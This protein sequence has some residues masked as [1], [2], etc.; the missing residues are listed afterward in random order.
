MS[1]TFTPGWDAAKLQ[2]VPVLGPN[3]TNKQK[4]NKAYII[5]NNAKRT[6]G[7]IFLTLFNETD[8]RGAIQRANGKYNNE[9]NIKKLLTDMIGT[10]TT[11]VID[12]GTHQ[13]EDRS[14]GGFKLHFD[15]RDTTSKCYHLYVG[16]S[17]NGQ[18]GIIEISY[19]NGGTK[20]EAHPT[21]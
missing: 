8:V 1:M 12:Q 10:T 17:L 3:P 18:L 19:M 2:P 7:A 6:D 11:I 4:K 16:Q 21:A 13:E 9:P 14:T 5:S 20:V 15:A